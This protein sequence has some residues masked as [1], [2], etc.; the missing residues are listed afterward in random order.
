MLAAN[1]DPRTGARPGS[2]GPAGPRPVD[3]AAAPVEEVEEAGLRPRTLAEFVGQRQ[4]VE[5]LGIVLAARRGRQAVDHLLF[6]GPPGLGKTSLAGI[7]A[8][9]MGVGL[10]ITSGPVLAR[11]GDLA[12]LL[13]DLQ[14][15]DVLFVDEIHRLHRRSKR[16]SIRPWRTRS[17][18]SYREGPDGPLDPTRPA[19]IHPGRGDHPHR[20][21]GGTA[22]G[23]LRVRGPA[24]PLRGR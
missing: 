23:P 3:P 21:G 24:R 19:S 6:A 13:T 12:A 7:V 16:S 2:G 15:G 9:E 22:A 20:S 5:H 17:W 1:A 10:R 14:E 11:A 8:T 4:L 18:T